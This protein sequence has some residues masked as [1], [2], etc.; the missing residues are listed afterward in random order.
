MSATDDKVEVLIGKLL[1]GE[2]SPL[3]QRLLDRQLEQDARARTLLEQM[4]VLHECSGQVVAQEVRSG[5]ADPQ[6]VFERAWRQS[7]PAVWRRVIRIGGLSRFAAGLAA[8]FVLGLI[9]HA[10]LVGDAK[11]RID[12]ATQGVIANAG[13]QN[14][15]RPVRAQPELPQVT[16][17]VE[18]YGFTDQAGNQWLVEG[19]R[20][21]V[22]TPVSYRGGL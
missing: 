1:D 19:F 15:F 18:W 3:E 12:G 8:G 6:D 17:Q 2:I 16:R 10:V 9:L 14:G 7:R 4:R 13:G 5:G 22:A 11:S 20:E 21:G